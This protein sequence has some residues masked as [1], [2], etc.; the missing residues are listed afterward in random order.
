MVEPD[1][2]HPALFD[3]RQRRRAR[4]RTL[5]YVTAPLQRLLHETGE[6]GVVIHI[7]DA[8]ALPAHQTVSGTCMTEKN[9]PSWR[10]ALAKP[11]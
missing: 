2:V 7:E 8:N 6:A 4:R 1:A 5:H 9:R 11:S 10:I 3:P